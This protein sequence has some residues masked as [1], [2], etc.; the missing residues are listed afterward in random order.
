MYTGDV[1]DNLIVRF[2]KVKFDVLSPDLKKFILQQGDG[3]IEELKNIYDNF[4]IPHECDKMTYEFKL[5]TPTIHIEPG[6]TIEIPTG[7]SCLISNPFHFIIIPHKY[8]NPSNTI[9]V[10]RGYVNNL[11]I[12]VHNYSGSRVKIENGEPIATG[13]LVETFDPMTTA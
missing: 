1:I 3:G 7:A 8:L 4:S 13:L 6:E 12:Q 5:C 2:S 9:Q 11:K 10:Y